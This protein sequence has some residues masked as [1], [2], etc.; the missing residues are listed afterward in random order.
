MYEDE[1][2]DEGPS[3]DFDLGPSR[4][5]CPCKDCRERRDREVEE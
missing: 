2:E 3:G 4:D 5:N 1:E